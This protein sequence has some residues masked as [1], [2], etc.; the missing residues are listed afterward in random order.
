MCFELTQEPID[1]TVKRVDITIGPCFALPMPKK[2]KG[3]HLML[4]LPIDR[5]IF[6]QLN[7]KDAKGNPI[8]LDDIDGEAIVALS[9]NTEILSVEVG[10]DQKIKVVPAGPLGTAQVNVEFTVPGIEVP[11]TGLLEVTTTPGSVA[12]FTI[13][14]VPDSM[15]PLG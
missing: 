8:S 6:L 14:P 15:F 11:F 9:S 5:G 4:K 12:S 7:P 2:K 13:D 1:R 10:A 3:F